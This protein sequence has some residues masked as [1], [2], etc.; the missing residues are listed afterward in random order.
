MLLGTYSCQRA[1]EEAGLGFVSEYPSVSNQPIH[2]KALT[3]IPPK[4]PRLRRSTTVQICLIGILDPPS[5]SRL[6]LGGVRRN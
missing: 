2:P 5:E 6:L 4:E 1:L 3:P